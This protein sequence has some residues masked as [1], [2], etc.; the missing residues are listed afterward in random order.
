MASETDAEYKLRIDLPGFC[1][2]EV[3]I[4]LA[5][6]TLTMSAKKDQASGCNAQVRGAI[7]HRPCAPHD[8]T[9]LV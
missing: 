6:N 5:G 2:G 1:A 8:Y 3:D 7:P 4:E 9:P